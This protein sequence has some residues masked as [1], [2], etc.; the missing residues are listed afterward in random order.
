MPVRPNLTVAL[1][2]SLAVVTAGCNGS[3]APASVVPSA[4]AVPSA[5]VG[6]SL[7]VP[8]GEFPSDLVT[9]LQTAVD[10][11]YTEEVPCGEGTCAVPLDVLAPEG[12]EGLPTIVLV[13]GG[14]VEFQWRRYADLLAA[15]LARRVGVVF[16]ISYR[17]TAMD[18]TAA[19][20]INDIGCAIRYAR[21]VTTEYGG[22]P[23][24]VVLVGH[25]LGSDFGLQVAVKPEAA[26][27]GCLAD[28]DAIPE[29]VVGMAGFSFDLSG[30]AAS[31]PPMW[32]VGGED[33]PQGS[34]GGEAAAERLR[35]AG[36]EAEYREFPETNHEEL[37]DPEATPGVVDLISLVAS[38]PPGPP[39]P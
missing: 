39:A 20:S 22:D 4:S 12:G 32:L 16:L 25:S 33:D 31:G 9:G 37:V 17:N 28:G 6:P 38:P 26:T 21:S 23:Q 36:F 3:Q 18:N 8:A 10:V 30:A 11:P 27:P 2:A 34:S 1:I 7:P 5:S 35:A 29:A 19:D 14:P 13:P 24:H 15:E